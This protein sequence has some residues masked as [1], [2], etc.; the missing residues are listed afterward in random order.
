MNLSRQGQL[1][2]DKSNEGKRRG[3]TSP[4]DDSIIEDFSKNMTQN[5]NYISDLEDCEDQPMNMI[6]EVDRDS[7]YGYWAVDE[8]GSLQ[9][10]V[11]IDR[12]P[13]QDL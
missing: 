4:A 13:K 12:N 2:C 6:H 5:A 10:F 1:D 9:A 8:E 11:K 3:Q 7:G